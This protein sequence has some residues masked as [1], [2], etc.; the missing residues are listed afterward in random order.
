[1]TL[2]AWIRRSPKILAA[3]LVLLST[4]PLTAD[5]GCIAAVVDWFNDDVI[6]TSSYGCVSV[7]GDRLMVA[8][9]LVD[10]KASSHLAIPADRVLLVTLLAEVHMEDEPLE[11]TSFQRAGY[12]TYVA[13]KPGN[14]VKQVRA[15]TGSK[16][17]A[18]EARDPLKKNWARTKTGVPFG[19]TDHSC[20]PIACF[21]CE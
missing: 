3:V 12:R 4:S 17:A 7:E 5:D 21:E 11:P 16:Q 8:Q 2:S 15:T 6:V 13:K 9:T 18:S 1:M 10:G 19:G 14:R 20:S